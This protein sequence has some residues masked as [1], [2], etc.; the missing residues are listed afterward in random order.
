MVRYDPQRGRYGGVDLRDSTLH[1]LRQR[2]VVVPQEGF[3]FG[4]TVRATCRGAARSNGRRH[5]RRG[6]RTRSRSRFSFS[7]G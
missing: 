7:E 2:I 3:L 1:P 4:G 6:R 5:R